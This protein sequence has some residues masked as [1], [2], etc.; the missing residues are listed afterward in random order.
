[1]TNFVA[2]S[3]MLVLAMAGAAPCNVEENGEC[4]AEQ[5]AVSLLQGKITMKKDGATVDDEDGLVDDEGDRALLTQRD[6]GRRRRK[7]GVKKV[8][9]KAR[10]AV[11][12][13]ARAVRKALP[14]FSKVFNDLKRQVGKAMN[15]LPRCSSVNDCY[16]KVTRMAQSALGNFFGKQLSKFG[17]RTLDHTMRNVQPAKNAVNG[18]IKKAS[19]MV[20]ETGRKV[21]QIAKQVAKSFRGIR[22]FRIGNMCVFGSKGLWYSKPTDC[23]AFG[24]IGQ[25][26]KGRGSINNAL[27]RFRNCV[28][29]KGP[30]FGMPT[31]FFQTHYTSLCVPGWIKT[32]I[33]YI[34]G[35]LRWAGNKGLGKLINQGVG[36]VKNFAKKHLRLEQIGRAVVKRRAFPEMSHQEVAKAV[37]LEEESGGCGHQ[38]NWGVTITVGLGMTAGGKGDLKISHY[39]FGIKGEIGMF[40]G[41]Y[42]RRLISPQPVFA[43]TLAYIHYSTT[44]VKS[45]MASVGV[46]IN[47]GFSNQYPAFPIGRQVN[48]EAAF[49]LALKGE[50]SVIGIPLKGGFGVNFPMPAIHQPQGFVIKAGPF[51]PPKLLEEEEEETTTS[52]D[53]SEEEQEHPVLHSVA[54]GLSELQEMGDLHQHMGDMFTGEG[55]LEEQ[56]I[57]TALIIDS[58]MPELVRKVQPDV[59]DSPALVETDGAPIDF[60]IG[61]SVTMKLCL[62]FPC[63]TR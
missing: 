61:G 34:L 50:L 36:Q 9:R 26:I 49:N 46:E 43:F 32:P 47:L 45:G 59:S 35:A 14:S 19:Q 10:R 3:M 21:G 1:M 5:S 11:R 53:L 7:G 37:A 42:R 31:P 30:A 39:G 18:M 48:I 4:V 20:K 27:K 17:K 13:A 22:R 60:A 38:S 62:H 33:E 54:K 6:T 57:Q 8:V 25:I 52:S 56:F 16:K 51:G 2:I 40:V 24:E 28:K 23:G 12:R 41:C 58:Q 55:S 15:F 44:E 63:R 29:L